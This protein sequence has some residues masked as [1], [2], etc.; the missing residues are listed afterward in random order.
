MDATVAEGGGGEL[1]TAEVAGEDT[2]GHGHEV[3]NDVNEDGWSSEAEKE[4]ELD[5]GGES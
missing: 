1:G 4:L 3:V 5:E 2:S